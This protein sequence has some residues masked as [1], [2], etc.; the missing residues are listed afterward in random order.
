MICDW[1]GYVIM[2]Y[3]ENLGTGNNIYAELAAVVLGVRL[4]LIEALGD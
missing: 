2:V 4:R 1:R 3:Q